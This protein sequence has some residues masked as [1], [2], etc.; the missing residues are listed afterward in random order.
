MHWQTLETTAEMKEK[1]KM[2][3][4]IS[5]YISE[6]SY[7]NQS[8]YKGYGQSCVIHMIIIAIG[9]VKYLLILL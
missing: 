1:C 9:I 5:N 3:P 2:L 4:L 7:S 8:I 6:Y